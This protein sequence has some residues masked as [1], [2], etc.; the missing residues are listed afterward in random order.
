MKSNRQLMSALAEHTRVNPKSRIEKLLQF[1]QRLY[2]VP[3]IT[4]EFDRWN[5]QLDKKL[6]EVPARIL[7]DEFIYIGKGKSVKGENADWTK[8]LR[9]NEMF[10][11]TDL[12]DWFIIFPRGKGRDVAVRIIF[13]FSL[14]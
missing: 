1:N 10:V 4:A 7:D 9:S 2:S 8:G 11:Q 12:I 13:D 3:E 14:P 5:L 6:V